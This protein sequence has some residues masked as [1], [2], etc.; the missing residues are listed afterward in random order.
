VTEISLSK[1]SQDASVVVVVA[2]DLDFVTIT[3]FDAFMAQARA[4]SDQVILDM[5]GVDFI[6]TSA[7]AVVVRHWRE[8][9]DRNGTLRLAGARYDYTRALWITG[10]A[11]WLPMYD[12]VAD[13]LAAA[14]DLSPGT[15]FGAF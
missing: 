8:L 5:S 11:E 15:G 13:A 1:A 12:N 14:R 7:L 4:D 9:S 6:D 3:Q 2:G 10:L